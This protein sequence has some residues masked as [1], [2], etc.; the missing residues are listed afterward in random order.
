MELGVYGLGTMGA[1]LARNA[2]RNGAAIAIFNRTKE[3]IDAFLKE[4]GEEGTFFGEKTLKEFIERL[5]PPRNILLMVSAGE[6]VDMLI[7]ELL[8]F[9]SKDDLLIDGGNSHYRDTERREKELAHKGVLYLGMGVSGGAEG[10][11]HGPSMMPGGSREGYERVAPLLQK[12]AASDTERG[13]CI[14]YLGKEGVGHFVKIVHNGIEYGLMQLLAESYD[15]LKNL[16][17]F[18][19]E[20]LA[21]TFEKWNE[22]EELRSF[23]I[24][25]TGKIFR[26]KEG[27]TFLV[28]L[29]KDSAGQK[30]TGKW[31]VEASMDYGVAVPT[32]AAG[33][34]ARILS[35]SSGLREKCSGKLPEELDFS[36]PVPAHE[37]MRYYVR[38]AL[39]LSSIL[40]YIQG[41]EL[42]KG[43]RDHEKWDL[44]LNEVAR[45]WQGG[46]IIRSSL[47][48]KF[49]A[50]HG[51]E[52]L[53]SRFKGERQYHF[54]H[55]VDLG[56]S[57]GIPLPAMCASLSYYDSLKRK[58]LPQNLTQ[59]QRDYFGAHGF[60]RTDKKGDF[61]EE[62]S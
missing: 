62:W 11:L 10:A 2:A 13:K 35:G 50:A 24:E 49:R 60:E 28:D 34:E 53:L 32:I 38:E 61:H 58:W 54:R 36:E 18:T 8:P 29:I 31:V 44:D 17:N 33:V 7:A 47:L 6:A 37:K 22:S 15:L 46:C 43:A 16:G 56:T 39:E 59:A 57:R 3:K 41:F 51:R 48:P 45:I 40:T 25:I 21:E 23:L 27:N 30:G 20:Q 5:D 42:L 26:T 1:N 52:V 4:Y 19:N 12:M 14:S 55:I 9:L